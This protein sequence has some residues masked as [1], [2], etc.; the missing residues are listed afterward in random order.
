MWITLRP[1][2]PLLLRRTSSW[3]TITGAFAGA[4][5]NLLSHDEARRSIAHNALGRA[6]SEFSWDAV[7]REF[8]AILE[9]NRIHY[10][11]VISQVER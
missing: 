11:S 8:E 4:C 6:Q 9:D 10:N 5:I 3:P 7:S 2:A 1:A